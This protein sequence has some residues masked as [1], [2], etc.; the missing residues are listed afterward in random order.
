MTLRRAAWVTV[1]GYAMTSGVPFAEFKIL[2][3]ILVVDDAARTAQNATA[4]HAAFVVAVFAYL[5]NFIGDIVAAWG[6]YELLRPAGESLSM[7]VAWLRVAFA[8]VGLAALNNLVTANR[9]LTRAQDLKALGRAQIDAEAF[10]A[11]GAF[12][13][14][15][16]F[17]LIFFGVYLVL[18]GW[19]FFRSG[20]L[21]KWLGV[22]LVVTGAGWVAN[23]G[24]RYAG[25]DLGFLFYTSFGELVLLVWLI[26]WG[27][28]LPALAAATEKSAGITK[29]T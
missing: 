8:A 13:S 11:I 7:F 3:A 24:G 4:H 9:L 26:G 28:R 2:P 1:V 17:G 19:L 20:Y 16:S 14:Q 23:I 15:F 21:P 5:A 22:V 29:E 10:V 18:L 25:G 6:L 27:T 12:R